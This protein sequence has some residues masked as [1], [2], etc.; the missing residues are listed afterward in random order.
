MKTAKINKA[1]WPIVSTMSTSDIVNG[2]FG[3]SNLFAEYRNDY[4]ESGSAFV[5]EWIND[6]V[7]KPWWTNVDVDLASIVQSADNLIRECANQFFN[8]LCWIVNGDCEQ[9]EK[10]MRAPAWFDAWGNFYVFAQPLSNACTQ[11]WIIRA[12]SQESAYEELIY[13]FESAFAVAE[14]DA[15]EETERN[16]SGTAVN[17][18]NLVWIAEIVE[19]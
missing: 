16:D 11:Y 15:D 14:D 5:A 1:F 6:N 8:A 18:E 12:D 19:G 17:T 10:L 13:R 9:A 3:G 7:N 2:Y 4:T